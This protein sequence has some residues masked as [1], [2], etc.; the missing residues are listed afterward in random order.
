MSHGGLP[1]GSPHRSLRALRHIYG[2]VDHAGHEAGHQ[3]VHHA[4]L[5]QKQGGHADQDAQKQGA[6]LHCLMLPEGSG[7]L[8]G[9]MDP[10]GIIDMDAGKHVGGGVRPVKGR[11][12]RR[13]DVLLRIHRR[14]EIR[15]VG[16]QSAY[17]QA[18]KHSRKEEDG[19]LLEDLPVLMVKIHPENQYIGEPEQVG[20]DE[21]FAEGNIVIQSHMDD[22]IPVRDVLLQ[23]PEPE[24]VDPSAQNC[25]ESFFILFIKAQ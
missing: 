5:L 1:S 14:T 2:T 6:P 10:D 16:I 13:K 7:L 9:D 19:H 15:S 4:V 12:G 20:N 3:H 24:K 18:Y 25:K 17:D 11:Y 22:M 8:H 23:K 21:I